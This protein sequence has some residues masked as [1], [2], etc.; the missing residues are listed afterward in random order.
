MPRD[1]TELGSVTVR[2]D[3]LSVVVGSFD[4]DEGDD[5]IWFDVQAVVADTFWPWSYGILSWRTENGYELGSCK[6]YT[7][8]VGEMFRIGVG[9][10]PRSRRGSVIY[11]PRSFNLGWIKKGNPLTLRFAAASGAS[12]GGGGVGTVG[13]SVAFPVVG[14]D[15]AYAATSGLLQLK[16]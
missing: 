12:G 11:E 14:A 2:P 13:G 10:A 6:A 8:S 7:E 16:L 15:W 9:R 5:T 4:I 3:D 1:W